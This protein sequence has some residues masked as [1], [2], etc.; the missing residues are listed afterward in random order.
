MA[1]PSEE[2]TLKMLEKE[3]HINIRIK[4]DKNNPNYVTEAVYVNGVCIRIPVG[5]DVSVPKTVHE[6]LVRKGV[7]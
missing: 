7:I 5:E 4:A 2:A 1:I 6:L 3:K